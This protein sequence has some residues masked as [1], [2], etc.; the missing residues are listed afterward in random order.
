MPDAEALTQFLLSMYVYTAM[1]F[2]TCITGLDHRGHLLLGRN[3]DF[4]TAMQP[5]YS[6]CVIKP[7]SGYAF[8]G[9]TTAF[10][11]MEDGIN[12][13]RLR[14]RTDFYLQRTKTLWLKTLE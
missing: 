10:V 9:N 7:T 5:M 4:L 2:C 11:E 6:H 12:E 8:T 1:N 14:S 3:S 13:K